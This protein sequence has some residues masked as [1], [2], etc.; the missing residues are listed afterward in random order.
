MPSL[1]EENQLLEYIK[2][3]PIECNV[4]KYYCHI[5]E[6]RKSPIIKNDAD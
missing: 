5:K 6:L 1:K 3:L 2:I 4:H